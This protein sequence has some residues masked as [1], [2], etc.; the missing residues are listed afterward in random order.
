MRWAQLTLVENDPGHYDLDF[1]LDY[2]KRIKAD[3]TCLS[4]GGYTAYYPT[5]IPYHYRSAWLGDGDAFGELVAGCRALGMVVVGRS[6]PHAIRQ[7][8]FDA[9][10]EWAAVD[11]E[12]KR[13]LLLRRLS[14]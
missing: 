6:D 1:W 10:P 4:A 9:H 2:F 13:H 3:A 8:A 12:G 7:D 5:K 14:G 11:R